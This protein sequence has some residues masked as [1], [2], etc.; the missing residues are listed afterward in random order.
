[1]KSGIAVVILAFV[2]ATA[3]CQTSRPKPLVAFGSGESVVLVSKAGE[4][5]STIRAF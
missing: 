4:V 1:M 3:R 2:V 5:V